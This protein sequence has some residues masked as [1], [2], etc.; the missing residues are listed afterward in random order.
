METTKK[1]NET[2]LVS[3]IASNQSYVIVDDDGNVSRTRDVPGKYV[4]ETELNTFIKPYNERITANETNVTNI[5]TNVSGI[6]TD[7]TNIETNVSNI[8]TNVTDIGTDVLDMETYLD[9]ITPK[10]TAK[11]NLVHITDALGLHTFGTK[12]AGQVRQETTTGKQL[13]N[14]K[15]TS[16]IADAVTNGTIVDEDGWITMSYDNTNGTGTKYTNYWT[17][18]LNLKENTKYNILCEVKNVSGTGSVFLASASGETQGQFTE[19]QRIYLNNLTNNS[20]VNLIG[21]T[22]ENLEKV[23]NGL[24]TYGQFNAGQ[25]GSVTFR[26]SVIEDTTVTPE[27]FI[28]EKYTGGQASPNPEFPQEVEVLEGYQLFDKNN[29]NIL[30]DTY[31]GTAG[32]VGSALTNNILYLEIKPNTSYTIQKISSN[33]FR[34]GTYNSLDV[35]GKTLNNIITNLNDS[36]TSYTLKN[37]TDKYLF[38]QYLGGDKNEQE[39]LDSII[40]NEGIDKK[41]YLPY[42]CIGY[43]GCRKNL[44]SQNNAEFTLFKKLEINPIGPGT[45]KISGKIISTDTDA[46]KCLLSFRKADV[47]IKGLY[48]LRGN[49]SETLILPGE[50]DTVNLYA[51]SGYNISVGDTATY[52]DLM[53]S[54]DGGEYEPYQ[55]QIVPLDLKG[56]WVGKI[57]EF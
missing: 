30:Y 14:Y 39:I 15:N 37:T 51:S 49:F 27:T 55:E 18:N 54:K 6:E 29:A 16:T 33:R 9:N 21:T 40:I 11:S 41:T 32:N 20:V 17:K 7:I 35:V 43:K 19:S 3:E 42:G 2:P 24:R 52:T 53:I 5:Q 23:T 56:N 38:F 31:I 57:N 50:I 46:D 1:L 26:L 25:N 48:V 13:Y 28:Y 47:E 44:L 45:Y 10:Q 8:E 22:K 4:T 12:S 36:I 34:V